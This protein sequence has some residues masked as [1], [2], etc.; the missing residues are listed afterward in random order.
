MADAPSTDAPYRLIRDAEFGEDVVVYSFTAPRRRFARQRL[1]AVRTD[2]CHWS[3]L[4][5]HFAVVANLP[6]AGTGAIFDALLSDPRGG[7]RT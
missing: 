5:E 1:R 6:F 2:A 4:R 3:W 7:R